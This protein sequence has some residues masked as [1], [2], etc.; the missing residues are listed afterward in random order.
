MFD[1]NDVDTN[2]S[3][4][5]ELYAQKKVKFTLCILYLNKFNFEKNVPWFK[6]VRKSV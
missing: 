1:L 4:F 6:A 2:V 3:E 5:I